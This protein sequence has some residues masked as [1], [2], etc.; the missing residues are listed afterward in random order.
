MSD[1]LAA[2]L[3]KKASRS[4]LGGLITDPQARQFWDREVGPLTLK[5]Q[6]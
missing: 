1:K 2:A 3:T 6:S 4:D 5:V